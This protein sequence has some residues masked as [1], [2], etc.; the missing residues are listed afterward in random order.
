MRIEA[1]RALAGPAE[2]GL[3]PEDR[4]RFDRALAE[5]VAAQ[6]YNADRPDGHGRL[7]EVYA[8]RRNGEG[9]IAEYR[10]AI[11]LDPTYVQAYANLADL[12]RARGVDGEA[13]AVLRSGIAKTPDAAA[14]HHAL[15][16]VLVRQKRT[17]DALQR[18]GR[19][20]ARSIRPTRAMHTC[21]RWRSTMR[22]S[23]SRRCRCWTRR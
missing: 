5:Y 2:A 19:G 4:T 18:I 20:V 22:A 12:Y 17:A 7:A 11:E 14:L 3:T 13:E 6:T 16:L 1:A 8:A 23:P 9:A 10:K 21:M 15:G